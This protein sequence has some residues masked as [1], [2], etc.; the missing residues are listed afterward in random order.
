MMT[1]P[2]IGDTFTIINNDGSD[3]VT[4]TFD[5][6]A[7]GATITDGN[8]TFTISYT[9]G[10]GNDVVLTT[11]DVTYTWSGLGGDSNWSTPAN[12]VGDAVPTPGADL[13]FPTG[14]VRRTNYD[15]LAAGF[16]VYSISTSGA[17]YTISGN[18]ID[19]TNGIATTTWGTVTFNDDIQLQQDQTL[20]VASGG[21]LVLAGAISGSGFGLTK[22]DA[23]IL[24]FAGIS[25]NT[26][27]GTT[28]VDAGTLQLDHP[29][30]VTAVQG[31]LVVGDNVGT[32]AAVEVMVNDQ[33][34]NTANV[35][36]N[37]EATL[38]LD[39]G[40]A[41]EFIGPDPPGCDG[42][43]RLRG[44]A[45]SHVRTQRERGLRPCRVAHPGPGIFILQGTLVITVA[46]DP[47]V[48]VNLQVSAAMGDPT[49]GSGALAKT[50]A[51]TMAI[52]GD[53][54]YTGRT[55]VQSGALIIE[56]SDAVAT[57]DGDL[58]VF[59]GGSLVFSGDG[60]DIPNNFLTISGTG[61][62]GLGAVWVASGSATLSGAMSM[63]GD[64]QVGAASR[65][66]AHALRRHLRGLQPVRRQRLDR[67][68]DPRR[69]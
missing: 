64:T 6:L 23:G 12:W 66:L 42:Q 36:V 34:A 37:Q 27:S 17:G 47:D 1:T 60:L 13:I 39:T 32:G 40:V 15:D 41:E 45:E 4:G 62:G 55:Y 29:A 18:A 65:R 69:R 50:G 48:P 19:L 30:S 9:G 16:N 28:Y 67:E 33:I 58:L 10:N 61:D 14:A 26:Y 8:V 7:Q 2:A 24:V 68:H 31:N 5:G 56:N 59:P 3:A 44:L 51:G 11:T 22:T 43:P 54:T 35:T 25:A 46:D 63:G 49:N 38:S 52:S 21:T 20:S 57:G 53:N